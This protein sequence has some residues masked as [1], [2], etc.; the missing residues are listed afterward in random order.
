MTAL[1][2]GVKANISAPVTVT[3]TMKSHWRSAA[4]ANRSVGDRDKYSLMKRQVVISAGK[5]LRKLGRCNTCLPKP[6]D[7]RVPIKGTT[8]F[9]GCYRQVKASELPARNP[10]GHCRD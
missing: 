9:R 8:D 5:A 3:M 1:W 4:Q 2:M 6:L 7:P 10:L